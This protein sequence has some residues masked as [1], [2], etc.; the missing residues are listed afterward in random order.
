MAITEF[1][2]DRR[3][4]LI[5]AGATAMAATVATDGVAAT[6]IIRR[7]IPKTG[8]AIPA[9][10]MGT[11]I[12]FNV[13][14]VPALLAARTQVLK[15]FFDL[16]GGMIDSS[17]MYG[18]AEAVVG[19]GL[20]KLSND[21]GL[22]SATK[23]WTGSDSESRTQIADSYRLWGIRRFDLFQVHNLVA[24]E[25]RLKTLR[26][27]KEQGRIRYLGITTSHGW[28]HSQMER[29]MRDHPL[30]FIQ[31]TYNPV[32]RLAENRLLPMARDKG[33]AVIVNRPFRR[34]ALIDSVKRHRLP[35]WAREAGAG[36]WAEFLLKY[37]ISHPA[38]TCAIPATSR[39]RHMQENMG[40]MRGRLPDAKLRARMAQAVADL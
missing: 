20:R 18:S 27:M 35:A 36:N 16:G 32:D 4:F 17:P 15:T 14:R 25:R 5:G 11:W 34:G 19:H 33:V 9:I 22:F 31:L 30:D 7:K 38:V 24:W 10:G 26:E 12:T 39:V 2:T 37:I 1:Q 23:V 3:S 21:K 40:A 29:I 13:G 28:R 6:P 8:E